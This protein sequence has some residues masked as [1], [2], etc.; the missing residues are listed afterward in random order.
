[1]PSMS[2]STEGGGG[3][4][5]NAS[6]EAHA[7]LLAKCA[8]GTTTPGFDGTPPPPTCHPNAK[9]RRATSV[10]VFCGLAESALPSDFSAPPSSSLGHTAATTAESLFKIGVWLGCGCGCK[11]G[12]TCGGG[13][14]R[15]RRR[16]R[17]R[18][19]RRCRKVVPVVALRSTIFDLF[20]L[21]LGATHA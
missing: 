9:R 19:G 6:S 15:G 1:M 10:R 12:C 4:R 17:G 16:R 14:R 20:C 3:S 13:G 2:L 21:D 7:P 8:S 5:A 18:R 11:C